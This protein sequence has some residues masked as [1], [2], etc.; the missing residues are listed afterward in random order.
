MRIVHVLHSMAVAGAEMLVHDFIARGPVHVRQSVVTLDSVGALGEA[1]RV[2]GIAV[3]C[4]ERKPGFDLGLPLRLARAIRE[5]GADVVHAH[6]YTPYFYSAL[7]VRLLSSPPA[8]VFTEH[9]RH[10]P[11][12]R[13]PKR[14]AF[15][16]V[17]LTW[18]TRVTAVC[19]Y[20][21]RLLVANEGIPP[22]RIEVIYNGVDPSR[23][24]GARENRALR[25]E[26]G[27]ADDDLVI[28]CVARFHPV[29]DHPTLLR[30]F[31]HARAAMP[32]ARLLLVG[33]GEGEAQIKTLARQL[34]IERS[35]IFA[36]VRADVPEILAASDIFA[37]TSLSEGTSVTLIEAMLSRRPVVVTDVGGNPEIVEAGRTGLLA[38]R[39]DVEAVG[40]ALTTLLEDPAR[41]TAFGQAGRARALAL[42]GQA[43]MHEAWTTLYHDCTRP[44]AAVW[45]SSA[46][47]S[48]RARAAHL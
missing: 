16:Q 3:E 13:R 20:I 42:F 12:E 2:R 40:R 23:F 28:V 9:G 44:R 5:M 35:V 39:G 1:L 46:R 19:A 14:V 45:R 47:P 37:M 43:R 27:L 7:A 24:D 32:R 33:G 38:P 30:A 48:F 18:T 8:L 34:G 10:Y 25:Q 17:A 11:D 21:K 29:K 4:L 15:N 6:Q 31:A 22:D 41:R 36:G 26:L